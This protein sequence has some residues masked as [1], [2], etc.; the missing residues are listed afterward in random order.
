MPAK[1]LL[2]SGAASAGRNHKAQLGCHQGKVTERI[3]SWLPGFDLEPNRGKRCAAM[4]AGIEARPS[5]IRA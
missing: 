4:L 1:Q 5:T 3:V 2:I